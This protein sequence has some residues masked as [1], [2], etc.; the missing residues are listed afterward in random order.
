MRPTCPECPLLQICRKGRIDENQVVQNRRALEKRENVRI[1]HVHLRGAKLFCRRP[2]RCS[3]PSV[4][5]HNIRVTSSAADGLKPHRT[6]TSEHV[7]SL[8]A[9][10]S[11]HQV[12]EPVKDR[13]PHPVGRR[14]QPLSV[15]H[16]Q[17][18]AL[19]ASAH[20]SHKSPAPLCGW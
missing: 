4:K 6:A 15:T 17:G 3:P 11:S 2:N 5:L 13:L 7:Q 12:S 19:E 9:V 14:S 16:C 8:Q 1:V 20:N 10:D 18:S